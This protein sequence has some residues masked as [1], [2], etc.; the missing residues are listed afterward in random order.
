MYYTKSRRFFEQ[1]KKIKRKQSKKN[2]IKG[3]KIA[4]EN[5]KL[6]KNDSM[7]KSNILSSNF[8]IIK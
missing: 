2:K 6:R 7:K 4:I 3:R 5:Q 8:Y 1:I